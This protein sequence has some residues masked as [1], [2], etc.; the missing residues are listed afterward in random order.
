MAYDINATD[1]NQAKARGNG[2]DPREDKI[3]LTK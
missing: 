3:F 2:N 1:Y